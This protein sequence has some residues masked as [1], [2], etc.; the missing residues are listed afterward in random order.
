MTSAQFFLSDYYSHE[1]CNPM[2]N[3]PSVVIYSWFIA[4]RCQI[5]KGLV[6]AL[7]LRVF[8]PCYVLYLFWMLCGYL[9]S[10]YWELCFLVQMVYPSLFNSVSSLLVYL[11]KSLELPSVPINRVDGGQIIFFSGLMTWLHGQQLSLPWFFPRT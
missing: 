9:S 3:L 8:S 1:L 11:C 6:L 10:V 2:I 7:V 5:K 4:L